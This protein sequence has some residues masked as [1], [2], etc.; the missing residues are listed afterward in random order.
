[1]S[2]L[3]KTEYNTIHQW[4]KRHYEKT[5][6]CTDCEVITKTHWANVSG[7]YKKNDINDWKEL[8]AKCHYQFDIQ[9]HKLKKRKPL[10][11]RPT[12]NQLRKELKDTP[13]LF[14]RLSLVGG[15]LKTYNWYT[16]S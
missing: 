2:H 11:K 6:I 14:D 10:P 4:M 7:E 15:R 16:P 13:I 3:T 5:G 1:M 8:C 12:I 9:I